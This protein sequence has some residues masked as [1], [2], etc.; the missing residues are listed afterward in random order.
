MKTG[1]VIK[2]NEQKKEM[3]KGVRRLLCIGVTLLFSMTF[4]ET[5]FA[6]NELANI[7]IEA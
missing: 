4:G 5:V 2:G 7:T 1:Y 3:N 6:D